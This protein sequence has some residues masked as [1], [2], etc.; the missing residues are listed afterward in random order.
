MTTTLQNW[1]TH[2]TFAATRV[3]YPQT[4]AQVQ[5]IVA[6]ASKVRVIGSRH[7]FHDL[8]DSPEDLISLERFDTTVIV[9]RERHTVTVPA[10]ITYSQLCPQLQ[11][12]G[13]ALTNLASLPQITVA[14]AVATATHGSGDQIGNLAT[15]VSGLEMVTASGDLVTLTRAQHGDQF[16]GAVVSL[17]GLGVVTRITLDVIP[18]FTMQ[19]MVYENLAFAQATGHFDAIMS[20][21]Y[22]VS[23]FTDWQ[24]DVVSQVWVKQRLP[25]DQALP[26]APTFFDAPLAPTHRHPVTARPADACTRQM[27]IPGPWHDRLPHFQLDSV[28]TGGNELQTEYFVAREHAVAALR[29]LDKLHAQMLP[30]LLLSEVRTVAADR[31]WLS[32]AYG[33]E[34]VGFH[35]SWWRKEWPAVQKLLPLIEQALAPFQPRPHW[36]KIFSMA[37]GRLPAL[38]P[39]WWDF[40]ELLRTYDPQGK[41]RNRFLDTYLFGEA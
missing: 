13:Y 6:R 11:H 9:D 41:F 12:Q 23:L 21:A 18:T 15:P 25:A 20:S 8:A 31:L 1:S 39:R 3:H 33:Q 16:D 34:T 5:E 38:Y 22:S 35:F 4:V 24:N 26:V 17:G 7:S 37:P 27:G 36:G 30:A 32:S 40:Q 14:G 29:A 28:L 10:G 19:Q 2:H